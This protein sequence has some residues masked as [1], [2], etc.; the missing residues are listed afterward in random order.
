MYFENREFEF[1]I[2]PEL[3]GAA[4]DRYPVVIIGG[5]PVGL[6][7][8]LALAR[9][10]V[11]SVLLDEDNTVCT[12]SRA[13]G[14]SRRTLE[15]W[16]AIGAG[17]R[18]VSHGQPW[19]KNLS[20]FKD[21]VVLDFD[22][23]DNALIKHRPMINLQQ[24]WVEKYLL[25]AALE[26]D[27]IEIRW[28]N[29]L[30]TV[31]NLDGCAQARIVTPAG[32]YEL[33][34]AYLIAADGARSTIRRSLNLQM[35]GT[36]FESVYVI[37]DFRMKSALPHGRR[38]WF[39]PA[40]NPGST[41][42]MHRQPDDV[43]RIDYPLPPGRDL[44]EALSESSVTDFITRHLAMMGEGSAWEIEWI[45][46]YKAYSLTLSDYVVGSVLF[47]GDAAHLIPIFGIRGLNSGVDDCWNL[48]WKL[49]YVLSGKGGAGL[50]D[51]FSVERVAAARENIAQANRSARIVTPPT[52]GIALMRDA[53]LSLAIGEERFREILNP[54]QGAPVSAGNSP[55]NSYADPAFDGGLALGESLVDLRVGSGHLLELLDPR[56]LTLLMFAGGAPPSWATGL[57]GEFPL[58]TVSIDPDEPA[59]RLLGAKPQ[60]AYLV[61]PDHIVCAKWRHP[62]PSGVSHAIRFALTSDFEEALP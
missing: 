38:A 35:E 52:D 22:I 49:S 14:M 61:R 13:L 12:G 32:S 18:I 51:S 46:H 31:R 20:Y 40:S 58:K 33:E 27:L 37:A 25:D 21:R 4:P 45:S 36:A 5:G 29:R 7:M 3:R 53:V 2:P 41:V 44:R 42:L 15:T 39:N 17:D 26:T 9:Q 10:G 8:A 1:E 56:R 23:P 50:L 57:E 24:S 34:A 11:R 6:T 62:E 55:L 30:E 60:S 47:V 16:E 19:R 28:N 48:A 59:G 54:R 43:W